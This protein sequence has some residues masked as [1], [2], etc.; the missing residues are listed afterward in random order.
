MVTHCKNYMANRTTNER[1]SSKK[2]Q[3]QTQTSEGSSRT[4]SIMSMSDFDNSSLMDS[5]E[6]GLKK[7]RKRKRR[8]PTQEKVAGFP[9]EIDM[10]PGNGNSEGI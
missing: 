8:I 1:F 5:E 4:S 6:N 7:L 3:R 2:V 10:V 9:R